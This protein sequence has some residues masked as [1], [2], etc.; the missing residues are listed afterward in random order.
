MTWLFIPMDMH[1]FIHYGKG[2]QRV[3][4]SRVVVKLGVVEWEIYLFNSSHF[5]LVHLGNGAIWLMAFH[6][7]WPLSFPLF[8]F[9]NNRILVL[10]LTKC[11][12]RICIMEQYSP[13]CAWSKSYTSIRDASFAWSKL[14]HTFIQG[15]LNLTIPC[16]IQW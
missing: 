15:E 12:Q 3:S 4:Q 6:I 13:T 9:N 16:T 14:R 11:E 7:F 10:V 2:L 1:F 5:F 8:S